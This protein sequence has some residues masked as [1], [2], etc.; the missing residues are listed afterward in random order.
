MKICTNPNCGKIFDTHKDREKHEKFHCG[1][2]ENPYRNNCEEGKIDRRT[3]FGFG[4]PNTDMRYFNDNALFNKETQTWQCLLCGYKKDKYQ[5]YQVFGH[6][7]ANHG[8]TSRIPNE[9]WEYQQK[10][11]QR[12]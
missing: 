9:R 7:A 11:I 4:T 12:K 1:N 3:P 10:K 6:I 2:P 5:W 8:Y